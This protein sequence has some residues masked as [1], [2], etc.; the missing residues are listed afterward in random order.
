M[1]PKKRWS[2]FQLK[3]KLK[4]QLASNLP[5]TWKRLS[6]NLAKIPGA[7]ITLDVLEV[8]MVEQVEEL[9]PDLEVKP[10]GYVRVLV[11]RRVGLNKGWVT[12]LSSLFVPI[13]AS[14]WHGELP[15]REHA[16]D[17]CAP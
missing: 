3:W 4:S 13:R 17:V 14:S 16:V 11:N 5:P 7:Q 10:L 8:W 1:V 9:E 2:Q 6:G 15:G 12:K